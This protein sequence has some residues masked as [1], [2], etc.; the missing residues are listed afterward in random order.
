MPARLQPNEHVTVAVWKELRHAYVAS[1]DG[2][3]FVWHLGGFGR[4]DESQTYTL[5]LEGV[6]WVRGH[7]IGAPAGDALA[8]AAALANLTRF[9]G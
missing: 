4:Y 7:V 6:T 2:D 5:A 9:T 3:Y 8:V 1:T